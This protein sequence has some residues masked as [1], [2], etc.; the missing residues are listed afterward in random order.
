MAQSIGLFG[1]TFNPIHNGHLILAEEARI[2]HRLDLVL[3]IPNFIPP[4]R[5]HPA[6]ETS[7]ELRYMMTVFATVSNPFFSVSDI[8][9]K[10]QGLSY[11][12]DTVLELKRQNPENRY[13]LI[14][15]ADAL[16]LHR[17]HRF[18]ELLEA[19][20]SLLVAD[21]ST[22]GRDAV[23]EKLKQENPGLVEK[24]KAVTMT[25]V[26]VSSTEIR[27]RIKNGSGIRYLVPESVEQFIERNL[28]YR[29]T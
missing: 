11:T 2:Q 17:W 13:S 3:F 4:H 26:A 5:T 21:R 15:G 27:E 10:R 29:S 14:T 24:L 25:P 9:I 6:L 20:E 12:V 23:A 8:E 1:G 7:A 22:E 18:K 16:T 28:L 19:V